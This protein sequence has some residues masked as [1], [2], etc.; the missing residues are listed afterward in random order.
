ML[1]SGTD[2]GIEFPTHELSGGQ[3]V[4]TIALPIEASSMSRY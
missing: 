2:L 3:V 4:K 1:E